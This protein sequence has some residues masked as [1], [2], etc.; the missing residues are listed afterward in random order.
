MKALN[1]GGDMNTVTIAVAQLAVPNDPDRMEE[2]RNIAAAASAAVSVTVSTTG[3]LIDRRTISWV[4]SRFCTN[5]IVLCCGQTKLLARE[6][7]YKWDADN[8]R[9]THVVQ[10]KVVPLT[11]SVVTDRKVRL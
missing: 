7:G 3:P 9:G 5:V 8:I 4:F 11:H 1:D 6:L 10:G 2:T